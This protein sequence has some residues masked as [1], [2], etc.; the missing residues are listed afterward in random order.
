[1]SLDSGTPSVG[2]PGNTCPGLP[3]SRPL[4]SPPHF[5]ITTLS[6]EMWPWELCLASWG[7][8]EDRIQVRTTGQRQILR[9][10]GLLRG[11]RRKSC[12]PKRLREAVRG[13]S[14]G[15]CSLRNQDN[16][17]GNEKLLREAGHQITDKLVGAISLEWSGWKPG[18][19]WW[20]MW[21]R[22]T[23]STS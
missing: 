15:S 13:Q 19:L 20:E 10:Q 21:K 2:I 4:T 17:K 1:M 7:S 12:L 22:N 5:R 11:R 8:R 23:D 14:A 3:D 18:C 9:K 16:F 6:W